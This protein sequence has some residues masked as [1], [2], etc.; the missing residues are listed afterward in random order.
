VDDKRYSSNWNTP[1]TISISPLPLNYYD[2]YYREEKKTGG[3]TS[4]TEEI[5]NQTS[6]GKYPFNTEKKAGRFQMLISATELTNANISSGHLSSITLYIDSIGTNGELMHPSISIKST[7]DSLITDFHQNGF[8]EVYNHSA[9]VSAGSAPLIDGANEF[10]F[11]TPFTWNGTDNLIIEYYFENENPV[12]NSILFNNEDISA[13]NTLSFVGKNGHLNFDGNNHVLLELSDTSFQDE[14]TIEFWAKGMG[15]SGN[16]TSILEGYD[17]LNNRIIN[18]HWPWN[19]NNFYFD[20]GEGSS[21]DRIYTAASASEIDNTWN[22]WA[23]VK[24]QSTGE[25]F[26]YKNGTLWLSGTGKNLNVGYLH[27]L[28]IGANKN[29]GNHWKGKIDELR[30]YNSAISQST[31]SAYYKNQINSSHPNWNNLISYYDFDDVPYAVDRSS[32]DFKIMPSDYGMIKFDELPV[33]GIYNPSKRPKIGFGYGGAT[34]LIGVD[35]IFMPLLKEPTIVF[36]QQTVNYHFEIVNSWRGYEQGAENT[37]DSSGQVINSVSFTPTYNL[38]NSQIT[39]YNTPYEII[40]DIEIARYITPYGIQFDLGPNG[41]SWIYDVTDYQHY[42]K[43]TVD[44]RAHNT[45]ELLDL[46]FAFIEGIPPRDIHKREAIWDDFRSYSFNNMANDVDLSAKNIKLSDTSNTFKIKTR[47][48][49]HGHQGNNNCCEWVS[50]NHQIKVDGVSRF[51]WNIWQPTECGDNPNISQGGTWPYAREGWCPGDKVKEYEFE[52]TPYVNSGDTVSLDYAINDVPTSDPGQGSGNYIG[53]FDLIS[54]SSANFQNDAAIVDVLNPN[55]WEYYSKWNPT[56]SNPRVLLRN[57]GEQNLVSCKI[58]CWITYG[59]FLEY[60]W[61]GNLAFLEEIVVEIPVNDQNWWHDLNGDLKFTAQVYNVNGTFGDDE[62]PD[63]SVKQT[64]FE[65]PEVINGPFYVW[66]TTN[67]KANENE[68]RLI[69]ES[70]NIV[71]ERTQLDNSTQYKDTFDLA[72]GC[73][74]I[75]ITD[76]DNDGLSFWYSAQVEGETAG[77]MRVRLVGGGYIEFFPG[78]FGNYHRYNF[79]VG[80]ALDVK[81]E[82][83]EHEIAIFPNPTNGFS[84]IEVSGSIYNDAHLYIYDL[85]GKELLSEEMNSTQFFAESNINISEFNSG[86]YVVKIVTNKRTYTKELIKN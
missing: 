31:I 29:I 78:D 81:E 63:N 7:T 37:Y 2:Y 53:A 10:L 51:N 59:N 52:L 75:I 57:T 80:F 49:G 86:T 71:F 55:N 41:F 70:G 60:E 28:V 56:C 14:I 82:E 25:M 64:M 17:T 69:D 77:T 1:D 18:I 68:Y 34:N 13:D 84:T 32:N 35:T 6:I 9:S 20:A 43:D 27:R 39:H 61:T 73:Y 54:Y 33:A 26:I 85:M 65:A 79:S 24:K 19:N 38:Y 16:N 76:S 8:I 11:H 40:E 83:L 62:Y 12:A 44:L 30:I 45:Q 23:F 58:R 47:M 5:N 22:H 74:S 48:T 21:Y 67:N 3:A 50:N 72:P 36:E 66:L 46:K 15:N 4:N 42:L